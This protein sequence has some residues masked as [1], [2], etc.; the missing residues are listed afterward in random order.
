MTRPTITVLVLV[1]TAIAFAVP[2][3]CWWLSRR[4]ERP[5]RWR[6]G[7]REYEVDGTCPQGRRRR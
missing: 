4:D 1:G 5:V 3:R 2:L 6:V 7:E